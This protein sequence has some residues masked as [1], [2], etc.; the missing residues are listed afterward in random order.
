MAD[1]RKKESKD[2]LHTARERY[3][4][5]AEADKHNREDAIA[6][7]RFVNLPGAQWTE[8]M[9]SVRGDRPCYEYNFTRVR[10][11]RVVN[12]IRG[13][14]PAGKVRPVEG[15]DQDIAEIYEGLIRNIWNT[16]HGD[17]ATD[18]AAEYQC[19]GG[20]GAWRVSTDY[21]DDSAFEQDL[22]IE[23]IENPFCLYADNQAT[24][25]MKRDAR[26]WI[27]TERISEKEFESRYGNAE[28]V[29]FE[30]D[31][32]FE[33]DDDQEWTDED[34]VRVAEYWYNV[35]HK[36]DLWLVDMP[37]PEN[38]EMKQVVVDSESDEAAGIPKK[39]IKK[40]RTV[41]TN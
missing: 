21:A 16:S 4:I 20:M 25:P 2:L 1:M 29:D 39:A 5:M 35:P 30:S 19:E 28:K 17:T 38:G 15:G 9:K 24:D 12:D 40:T 34:T 18:Y 31:N 3:K 23:M 27:L 32:E 13:N 36:K 6:D 10:C 33:D 26:D 11:K 22:V 41:D 8:N 37:D 7:I 14:R